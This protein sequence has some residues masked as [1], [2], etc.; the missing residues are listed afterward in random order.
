LQTSLPWASCPLGLDNSTVP[1]CEGSSET[2]FFWFRTTL[3]ASGSIG[4]AST[5]RR[6]CDFSPDDLVSIKYWV[7]ICLIIS[8]LIIYL[9]LCKGIASSGKVGPSC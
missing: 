6:Y 2:Q 8:W 4:E 1:E 3:D 7:F 9:I 5:P